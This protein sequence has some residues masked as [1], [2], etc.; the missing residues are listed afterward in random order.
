[1][2]NHFKNTLFILIHLLF[3]VIMVRAEVKLPR[4]ISEGMVLQRDAE[5]R[6]WGW[7][8]SGEKVSVEFLGEK[9]NTTAVDGK[10]QIMLPAQ[11]YKDSTYVAQ[12]EA[13]DRRRMGEWYKRLATSDKG[14]HDP[15]GSWSHW[16][17]LLLSCGKRPDYTMV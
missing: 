16:Q 2:K 4:L 15:K 17:A 10:W 1:M 13:E 8:D 6:V 3:S 9:Y 11:K 12:I 14:Y 5:I 7:A